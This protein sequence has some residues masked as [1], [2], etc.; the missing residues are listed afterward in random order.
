[1]E[2]RLRYIAM[3]ADFFRDLIPYVTQAGYAQALIEE[4]QESADFWA[5]LKETG[6]ILPAHRL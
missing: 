4:F 6:G 3:R 5:Q 1:V 2:F